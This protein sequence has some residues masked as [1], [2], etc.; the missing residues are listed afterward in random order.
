MNAMWTCLLLFS[1]QFTVGLSNTVVWTACPTNCR[2]TNKDYAGYVTSS[3]GLAVD[4]QAGADVDDEELSD[5]LDLLL[6]SNQTYGH[7][8]SLSIINS[9]LTHVPRSVCR[10]TTLTDLRLDYNRL[11]RLPDNCLSNLSNLVSF[12]AH[13]NAIAVSYTHLTLPTIYSV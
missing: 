5:Q 2:C 11:T 13:D 8:T 3:S 10:L 7:L 1:A 12:S 4:C 6:S 9:S